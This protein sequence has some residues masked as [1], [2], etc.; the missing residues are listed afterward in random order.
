MYICVYRLVVNY[1]MKYCDLH[2]HTSCS[3]GGANP[4]EILAIAKKAGLSAISITDHN[5]VEGVK[6]AQRRAKE[7]G[8]EVLSGIE[9]DTTYKGFDFHIL[10]YGMDLKNREFNQI[11]KK[12]REERKIRELEMAKKMKKMGF[13]MNLK[14]L[15]NKALIAILSKY[16]IAWLLMKSP[17]NRERVYKEVGPCPT[18]HDIITYYLKRGRPAYVS[19]KLLRPKQIIKLIKD[20]GGIPVLAH[21]GLI[22]PDWKIT[23]KN[24]K[25]LK[26]LVKMGIEGFEIYTPKNTPPER[27]HYKALAKKMGILITG[28]S[29]FH[30]GIFEGVWPHEVKE[31]GFKA[32]Y[33]VYLNLKKA[34]GKNMQSTANLLR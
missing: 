29:D 5:T 15:K 28:G 1:T 31:K 11:L 26:E 18:I 4:A 34:L 32:P 24:D 7:F 21:P 30:G 19:K 3:D 6:K 33:R 14:K 13:R 16:H 9:I 25:L 22:H 23:Y 10:G 12:I 8:I 17:K 2:I 27:K 20:A